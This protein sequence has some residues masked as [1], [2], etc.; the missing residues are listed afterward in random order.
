VTEITAALITA[1]DADATL[2]AIPN[3]FHETVADGATYPNADYK[4]I[5]GP[6]PASTFDRTLLENTD[7]QIRIRGT[8]LATLETYSRALVGLL[9]HPATKLAT[10]QPVAVMSQRSRHAPIVRTLPH[11]GPSGETVYEIAHT[12]R[13]ETH[14]AL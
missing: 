7:Y 12:F 13:I 5:G 10:E 9:H 3:P 2:T 4:V 14:R 8:V 1:W 11:Y 6:P